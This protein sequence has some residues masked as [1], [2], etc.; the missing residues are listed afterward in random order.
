MVG[1]VVH[2]HVHVELLFLHSN[3]YFY[4]CRVTQSNDSKIYLEA[5]ILIDLAESKTYFTKLQF[6][7]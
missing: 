5:C 1:S 6:S 3:L 4:F 7:S 2:I